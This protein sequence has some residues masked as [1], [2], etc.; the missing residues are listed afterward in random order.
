MVCSLHFHP[1][2]YRSTKVKKILKDDALPI[3]IDDSVK[4]VKKASIGDDWICE[5]F[6]LLWF[7]FLL[8][9]HPAVPGAAVLVPQRPRRPLR[10]LPVPHLPPGRLQAVDVLLQP[11]RGQAAP[12]DGRRLRKALPA[13]PA[14]AGRRRTGPPQA[15]RGAGALRAAGLQRPRHADA[16]QEPPAAAAAAAGIPAEEVSRPGQRPG[17]GERNVELFIRTGQV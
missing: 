10:P 9:A 14:G 3:K 7:F 5:L 8:Q 6:L 13:Q 16:T 15:G 12:A 4:L 1:N 17:E 11:A 2:S